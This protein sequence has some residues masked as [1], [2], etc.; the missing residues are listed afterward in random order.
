M[1]D[2]QEREHLDDWQFRTSFPDSSM[3]PEGVDYHVGVLEKDE[4]Y[5][6]RMVME[7]GDI[8][9]WYWY[10]TEDGWEKSRN[11]PQFPPVIDAML[12]SYTKVCD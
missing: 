4:Y 11:G 5:K 1:A 6:A 3:E 9:L 12:R 10:R 2:G 8:R 7:S